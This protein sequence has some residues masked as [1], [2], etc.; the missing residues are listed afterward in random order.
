MRYKVRDWIT[1]R[2]LAFFTSTHQRKKNSPS[3]FQ[4]KMLFSHPH[5]FPSP[6]VKPR[7]TI[8][9]RRCSAF[10]S[11]A[12][13]FFFSAFFSCRRSSRDVAAFSRRFFALDREK[14]RNF[15][16][17]TLDFF[18]VTFRKSPTHAR[19]FTRAHVVKEQKGSVARALRRRESL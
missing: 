3:L 8:F 11:L 14:S 1:R 10:F 18:C 9:S 12:F 5:P 19:H 15:C 17:R 16:R 4:K 2:V 13:V 6:L 7:R